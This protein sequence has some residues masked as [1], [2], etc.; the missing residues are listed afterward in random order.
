MVVVLIWAFVSLIPIQSVSPN[1]IIKNSEINLF[2]F[3]LELNQFGTLA[4][5][6]NVRVRRLSWLLL[7]SHFGKFWPV[8]SDS[9]E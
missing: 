4:S 6:I 5:V 2:Q 1:I 7:Q 3:T 9:G 8:F